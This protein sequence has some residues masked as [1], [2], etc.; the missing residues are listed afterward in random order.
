MQRDARYFAWAA[1]LSRGSLQ[2][3]RSCGRLKVCPY[4]HCAAAADEQVIASK[5]MRQR[6]LMGTLVYS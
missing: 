4:I 3:L 2:V 6:R 5:V 1:A